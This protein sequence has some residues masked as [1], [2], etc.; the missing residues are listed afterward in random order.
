MTR[1]QNA[2]DDSQDAFS[3]FLH[4]VQLSRESSGGQTIQ[5]RP[6]AFSFQS[7]HSMLES[8]SDLVICAWGKCAGVVC[9]AEFIECLANNLPGFLRVA[10]LMFVVNRQLLV[11]LIPQTRISQCVSPK[12]AGHSEIAVAFCEAGKRA[13]GC[14]IGFDGQH[15]RNRLF[16]EFPRASSASPRRSQI[17]DTPNSSSPSGSWVSALLSRERIR[18]ES[19]ARP[20]RSIWLCWKTEIIRSAAR[21]AQNPGKFAGSDPT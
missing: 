20:R 8:R 3:S 1:D 5:Q 15:G 21:R 17:R 19:P 18:L 6:L 11:S 13:P 12:V 4:T 14:A 16:V 9:P 10:G 2:G 7:G